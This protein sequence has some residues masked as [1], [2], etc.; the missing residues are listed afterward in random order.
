MID[1]VT[2]NRYG[3]DDVLED[4]IYKTAT[5]LGLR[6]YRELH[7]AKGEAKRIRENYENYT[8]FRELINVAMGKEALKGVLVWLNQEMKLNISTKD[9]L[10]YLEASDIPQEILRILEQLRSNAAKPSPA[11][12]PIIPIQTNDEDEELSESDQEE[13]VQL[14]WS[15]N[16]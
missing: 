4:R 1:T 13:A 15:A 16:F 10:E 2:Q 7:K 8:S 14:S 5:L 9:I 6:E 12:L 3:F 11:S